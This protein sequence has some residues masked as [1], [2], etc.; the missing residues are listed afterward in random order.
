MGEVTLGT[1]LAQKHVP[2]LGTRE[3]IE[4]IDIDLIDD[5]PRNFYELSG[6]DDLAANIELLGLQQ[7]IRVRNHPE[8]TGRVII[9]SGH[10]RRAAIRTLAEGDRERWKLVPCI[11]ETDEV[12]PALQELR[13]IYANS[14]TRK[15]TS[16]DLSKQAERVEALLYQLKEEGYE[17][18]GRMRDHVAQACQVSRSKL[19]RLKVIR[20]NLA[21]VWKGLWD[22]G[23]LK[24]DPAYEL[25]R[26]PLNHQNKIYRAK[27]SKSGELKYF[28]SSTV[29]VQERYLEALDKL[30]C[31]KCD[32]GP[33]ENRDRKYDRISGQ[34]CYYGRCENICCNNC[35][36]LGSCRFACPMLADKV[37]K[38][39]SDK[40]EARR[41]ERLA[42]EAEEN[43]KIHLIENLWI[44]FGLARA[45]AGK[46]VKDFK[47]NL[48]MYYS[49]RDQKEFEEYEGAWGIK[50][51]T[52]LPYGYCFTYTEAQRLIAAADLLGCSLDY[53]FCRTN[54]PKMPE[55]PSGQLVFSGWMPGGT[56]P[57]A[58]CEVVAVF[59][60]GGRQIKRFCSWNGHDFVFSEGGAKIEMPVVKWM[61]LPPDEE[62][63]NA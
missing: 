24:E 8:D 25:A 7:P 49:S 35:E 9:V 45:A 38:L 30:K 57:P 48:G 11:R 21:D 34:S 59:D 10:R 44:R 22:R 43:P 37:Q 1:L 14:D 41:Q 20:E 53:L 26:L 23:E 33:C 46:S 50:V 56:N 3:K 27:M 42:K 29:T 63:T 2:K 15:M 16:A 60:L 32:G 62:E 61:A 13:L 47:E 28:Y 12:S 19:A 51:S 40:R 58:P 54:E 39:K 4:Y 55:G 52:Q 6:L 5:D 17:F 18:P 36:D 31:E